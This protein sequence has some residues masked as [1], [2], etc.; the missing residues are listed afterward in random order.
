MI[1]SLDEHD[2]ANA[3]ALS[4]IQTAQA[5]GFDAAWH[6]VSSS[7]LQASVT[8]D[9]L[10]GR[11]VTAISTKASGQV[12][13]LSYG[14]QQDSNKYDVLSVFATNSDVEDQASSMAAQGYIITAVGSSNTDNGFILVGTRVQGDSLP[15]SFVL[16]QGFENG[17]AIVGAV[18]D[19]KGNTFFGEK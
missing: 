12:D 13:Y 1:T 16:N 17:Y 10:S 2:S 9:G 15:R 7:D 8:A 6:T 18:F 4:Y 3:F 19:S 14:W 11:V 5:T